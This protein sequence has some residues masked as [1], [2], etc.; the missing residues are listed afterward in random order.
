[1]KKYK[2]MALIFAGITGIFVFVFFASLQNSSQK[3][4]VSVV[5]ASKQVGKSTV[6]TAD[7]LTIQKLP[8]Q[9]VHA[10]AARQISDVTGRITDGSLEKGEQVLVSKLL[11]SGSTTAGFSY[12]VPSG[13]RAVT[14]L[15]DP[16]TGVGGLLRKSDRVDVLAE[17]DVQKPQGGDKIATS[18]MLLQNIEVLATGTDPSSS[19]KGGYTTVTL[20]VAPDD[21]VKLNLAATSGKVRLSLRPQTDKSTGT[22]SPKTA[23]SLG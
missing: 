19:S 18:Y 22:Y 10:D 2:I 12:Q 1:M 9:A 4:Y 11:K 17:F 3:N 7:M 14:I 8:A 20:S 6:L 16:V 15:V 21:S 13:M 5:V 23:A